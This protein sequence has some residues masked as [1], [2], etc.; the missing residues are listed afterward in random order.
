[1][2]LIILKA[3]VIP[4]KCYVASS[5]EGLLELCTTQHKSQLS[6]WLYFFLTELQDTV[7]VGWCIIVRVTQLLHQG[8]GVLFEL[9]L[10]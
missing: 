2:T 9:F 10:H 4:L 3:A 1:M 7:T 5:S 6:F 8:K